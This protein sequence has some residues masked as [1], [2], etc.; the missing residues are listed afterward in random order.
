MVT[1]SRGDRSVAGHVTA[2][3]RA[4]A[5]QARCMR[6]KK[7]HPANDG[8]LQSLCHD[9]PLRLHPV[10]NGGSVPQGQRTVVTTLREGQPEVK[11][12]SVTCLCRPCGPTR[13]CL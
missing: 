12:K 8:L 6:Q 13:V 4:I 2:G 3:L 7:S 5:H 1:N 9:I 11:R 10:C